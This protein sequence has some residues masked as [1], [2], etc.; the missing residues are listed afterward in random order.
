MVGKRD[1]LMFPNVEELPE[2]IKISQR[3]SM[4]AD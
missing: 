4:E 3:S 2:H 1:S